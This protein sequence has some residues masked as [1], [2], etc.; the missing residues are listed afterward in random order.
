MH[1]F[2]MNDEQVTLIN[3]TN[4]NRVTIHSGDNRFQEFSQLVSAGKFAEAENLDTKAVVASFVSSVDFSIEIENG[5]GFIHICNQ[6]YPLEQAI[7]NKI[8]K[9]RKQGFDSTPLL[10]FLKNLYK[11]PSKVAISELYMFLEKAELPITSD[12]YFIAYKV[13]RDD[14]KDIHSGKFDNSVGKVCEMPRFE[15]DDVRTNTC[16]SGLHFCSRSYLSSF[17]SGRM[18]TDRCVLVKINPADV[19]SIPSD[20][21]NAKGRTC[22]YEVVG[23]VTADDWRKNLTAKNFSQGAVVTE[24]DEDDTDLI[25]KLDEGGYYFDSAMNRWRDV[26]GKLVSRANL[27]TKF[28]VDIS[29]ITDLE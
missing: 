20:Y 3:L 11:N 29:D 6:R 4:G 24:Y 1:T 26:S 12:G 22:R 17:G 13:I 5:L 10:K 14:Y 23:E 27:A 9:M 7:V 16:S 19:V 21:D 2:F 8:V 18:A 15:V 28:D 25:D